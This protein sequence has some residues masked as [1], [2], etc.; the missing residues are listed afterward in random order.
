MAIGVTY[1]EFWYGEPELVGHAIEVE[2]IAAK[3]KAIANDV[4]AWNTGRYVMVAVSTVLSHAF[5][6]SST[7]K[8]PEEPALAYEL[9][10]E[11]KRQ[12]QERELI[13]QRDSFLALAQALA[14]RD[15]LTSGEPE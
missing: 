4:L 5:S 11:L 9:D 12:K 3:N 13:R 2:K 6:K 1:D 14:V 8:Y 7:A 10:E 15:G